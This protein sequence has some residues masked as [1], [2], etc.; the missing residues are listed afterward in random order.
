[1]S[2]NQNYKP[3]YRNEKPQEPQEKKPLRYSEDSFTKDKVIGKVVKITL[4]TGKEVQGKIVEIGMYDILIQTSQARLIVMKS[5]IV[6]I[7]VG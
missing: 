5:A 7:E 2:Y 1:M 6:S 4:I 3:S